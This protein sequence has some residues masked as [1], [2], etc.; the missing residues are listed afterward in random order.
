[1]PSTEEY[2]EN[3]NKTVSKHFQTLREK[4]H[5]WKQISLF[6]LSHAYYLKFKPIY[7]EIQTGIKVRPVCPCKQTLCA[8]TPLLANL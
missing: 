4:N 6:I 1:M 5:L 7:N 3:Q 2:G 8:C